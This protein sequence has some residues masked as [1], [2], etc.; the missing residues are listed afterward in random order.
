[1]LAASLSYKYPKSE[2]PNKSK[3]VRP[4]KQRQV[5]AFDVDWKSSEAVIQG[6]GVGSPVL[7]DC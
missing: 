2:H 4:A 6:L 1:M 7:N 3:Y 5:A